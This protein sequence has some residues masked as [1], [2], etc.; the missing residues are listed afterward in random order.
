M[1]VTLAVTFAILVFSEISPKVVAS[2][3]SERI[4]IFSGYLLYPLLKVAYP[5]VWFV[6][7]F[8]GG[9][10]RI[11]GIK[12]NFADSASTLTMEELRSIVSDAGSYIPKKH[13]A[14]LL[15]LFDLEKITVEIGRAHV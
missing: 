6:N 2:A 9:L 1:L 12:I 15:N 8:V 3:H 11:L 7:L 4:A 14:I 13:R 10:L 5:A